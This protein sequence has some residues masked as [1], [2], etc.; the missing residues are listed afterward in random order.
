MPDAVVDA[1]I[2]ASRALVNITSRA[3]ASANEEVTLP[4][5]RT[6]VALSRRGPQ[7]VTAL[8]D[9]LDVHA[10]TMTRMCTR[11]VARGLVVRVPSAIDRRE[12]V[13]TLSSIGTALVDDV[14]ATRRREFDAIAGRL[15]ES[16]QQAAIDALH[17]F[18]A[19]A[20]EDE[21]TDAADPRSEYNWFIAGKEER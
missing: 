18:A 17:A 4:Q 15:S 14:L 20:G 8:A 13:I 19:A 12:V 21:A 7:T 11:L 16:E 9:Q 1:L 10:S 2:R 5:F 6:L 3:L